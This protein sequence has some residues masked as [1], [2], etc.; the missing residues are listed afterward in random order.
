M[1][2]LI[3]Y[4]PIDV[5]LTELAILRWSQ[6]TVERKNQLV[7]IPRRIRTDFLLGSLGPKRE[8]IALATGRGSGYPLAAALMI[9]SGRMSSNSERPI[10]KHAVGSRG[11]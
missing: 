6:I 10:N 4:V 5:L 3:P 11:L 7:A 2:L 9:A 8:A 1:I